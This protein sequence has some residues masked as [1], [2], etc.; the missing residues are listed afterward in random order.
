[1]A[2]VQYVQGFKIYVHP[3]CE[4]TIEELNTYTFDQDNEGNWLNKPIDKNNHALD[5]LRY[6]LEDLIFK[7]T[8][9]EDVNDLRRMKGMLRG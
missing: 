5:A 8:E 2:G 9:K 4:H 3:S 6:S 7:R 1:M